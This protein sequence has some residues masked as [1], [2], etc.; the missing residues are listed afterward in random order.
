MRAAGPATPLLHLR[1]AHA[2]TDLAGRLTAE[3]LA[4][5]E[6][7]VYAQR[8][9]PP[10]PEALAV[11]A[12]NVPVLVPLFSP[13]S[14]RLAAQ[15]VRAARRDGP[16]APLHAVAI[17]EAAARQ[18]RTGCAGDDARVI[19]AASPDAR[20]MTEALGGLC[21]ELAGRLQT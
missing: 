9:R 8:E 3:G 5:D 15:A 10:T 7:V 19:V 17:S 13:R 18:W 20:G 4:C 1:G 11:L 6:A 2:V 21:R 14:A 16:G 12:G